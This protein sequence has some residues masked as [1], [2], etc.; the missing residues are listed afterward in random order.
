MPTLNCPKCDK[1]INYSSL[2]DLSVCSYCQS[3]LIFNRKKL[4]KIVIPGLIVG[5]LIFVSPD[6]IQAPLMKIVILGILLIIE[7]YILFKFLVFTRN[8]QLSYR[9]K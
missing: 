1:T 2:K 8:P 9:S 3:K 7:T 6:K 4:S 5:I